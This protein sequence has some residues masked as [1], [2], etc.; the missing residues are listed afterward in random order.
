MK[1]NLIAAA[2]GLSTLG[3]VGAAHATELD[4]TSIAGNPSGSSVWST[5][6]DGI[7]VTVTPGP[8]GTRLYWD[9]T[10]G[11]GVSGGLGYEPDEIDGSESLTL[12]F[13]DVNGNPVQV[14]LA[15]IT[16][17][18]LF[19]EQQNNN[20]VMY[21]ERG[22]YAINGGAPVTFTAGTVQNH[23]NANGTGVVVVG[24]SASTLVLTSPGLTKM[25]KQDH[26]FSLAGISFTVTAVP[27]LSAQGAAAS[28]VLLG[29]IAL[30]VGGR[31][32]RVVATSLA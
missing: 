15:T 28:L 26:E 6:V 14:Q 7:T 23:D 31:R 8:I 19:N 25:G 16:V 21:D 11:F 4:F 30:I 27:E 5:T 13:T 1:K 3:A 32:R 17:S 24:Q 20:K 12:T 22:A 29:G 10:D 9:S 18:D 2:V